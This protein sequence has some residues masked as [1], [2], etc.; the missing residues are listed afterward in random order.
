MNELISKLI[1]YC[2]EN[3]IT[4]PLWEEGDYNPR[5]NIWQVYQELPFNKETE[6]LNCEN[7]EFIPKDVEVFVTSNYIHRTKE[8]MISMFN[9]FFNANEIY[10]F[11]GRVLSNSFSQT[12]SHWF[13]E[14]S[15]TSDVVTIDQLLVVAE[16]IILKWKSNTQKK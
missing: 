1:P 12:I 5:I 2:S 9:D 15:I 8:D 4:I 11:P 6:V 13:V 14:F 3:F 7:C 16:Q 10:D